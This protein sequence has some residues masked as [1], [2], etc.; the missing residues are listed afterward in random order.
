MAL[1][2]RPPLT[3]EPRPRHALPVFKIARKKCPPIH[4]RAKTWSPCSV[5]SALAL[6]LASAC[7]QQDDKKDEPAPGPLAPPSSAVRVR[8]HSRRRST[9][10]LRSLIATAPGNKCL[11]FG[12]GSKADL[13]Q[14]GDCHLQRLTR[15]AVQAAGWSPGGYHTLVSTNSQKCLDVSA[16]AMGD[17]ALVQQYVL[18]RRRGTSNG[19]SWTVGSESVRLVPPQQRQGPG[20]HRRRHRRRHRGHPD[21][22]EVERPVS[23]SS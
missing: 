14:R 1:E 17:G 22:L 7:V 18:Q 11:Q 10:R 4:T 5:L 8:P 15:T 12:G 3:L 21:G 19:S 23:C 6:A 20:R 2:K 13:A 16:F 9:S